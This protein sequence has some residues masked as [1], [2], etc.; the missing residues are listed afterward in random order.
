MKI[1]KLALSNFRSHEK[2]EL[3]LDRF[4]FIVGANG[5][6]KSS[7]AQAIEWLFTGI[8]DVT[9]QGG[10]GADD[11]VRRGQ[12]DCSVSAAITVHDKT[13]GLA[14]TK[15]YG[16]GGDLNAKVG[17]NV[18]IGGDARDWLK[19][20]VSPSIL[21]AVLSSTNFVELKPDDQKRLLAG[22][23]AD[24]GVL[25]PV[26]LREYIGDVER[27]SL[28]E[29]DN[30]Y[31]R[32]FDSRT[33]L[34]KDLKRLSEL[35]EPEGDF[36]D[37]ADIKARIDTIKKERD[38]AI[39]ARAKL[40]GDF[41]NAATRHRL[42]SNTIAKLKDRKADMERNIALLNPLSL[43][44]EKRLKGIV[45]AAP[46]G[47]SETKVI[48]GKIADQL[49]IT[50]RLQKM[51]EGQCPLCTR[52]LTKADTKKLVAVIDEQIATLRGQLEKS[53]KD[54]ELRSA[55][56]DAQAQIA[57]SLDQA[58]N[59][60]E[61]QKEL[62]E[63]EAELKEAE[64]DL[65]TTATMEHPETAELDQDIATLDERLSL[66]QKILSDATRYKEQMIA[67]EQSAAIKQEIENSLKLTEKVIAFA[68]PDGARKEAVG[69]KIVAF[70]KSLN[71]ALAQF[72]FEA[73]F[74]MDPFVM[75]VGRSG[76]LKLDL[77]MLSTSEKFRFATAFQIAL[78]Q[79]T[80][81][82][83]V[84]IDFADMLDSDARRQLSVMLMEADIDQAIVCS[85]S[86]DAAPTDLPEG[87]KF[88]SLQNQRDVTVLA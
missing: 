42:L 63:T 19:K 32:T 47:E 46:K 69:G 86:T 52:T 64:N 41:S 23:L 58:F 11:L 85:T 12:K 7:I 59:K 54:D 51:A 48:D 30:L 83:L 57:K 40:V 36:A 68:G 18:L 35:T 24:E 66:G 60:E 3:D 10:K 8:C 44:E 61:S 49:A 53:Q 20:F 87:V 55:A 81:V 38:E 70:T 43:A 33:S 74:V 5:A 2:T 50:A 26:E 6:G 27:L 84:V 37:E 72:G 29:L 76:G 62:S 73:A 1:V 75:R 34:R 31:K 65:A 67:Y 9:D 13:M 88:F 78:A 14:R 25:V 45:D 16:Q 21:Q 79:I 39:G 22:V 82:R 56:R 4:N 28:A 71:E 77:R 80:G 15:I 17:K